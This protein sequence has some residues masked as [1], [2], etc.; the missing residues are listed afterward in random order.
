MA[1]ARRRRE[2]C[3]AELGGR[4]WISA[5]GSAGMEGVAQGAV[6]VPFKKHSRGF[7]RP[8]RCRRGEIRGGVL[9]R[10]RYGKERMGWIRHAG[11]GE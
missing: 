9:G 10:T 8:C 1:G 11:P 4:G 6:G 5:S 7:G 2:V 3:V